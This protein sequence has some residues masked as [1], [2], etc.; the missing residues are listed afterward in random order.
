[1]DQPSAEAVLVAQ[2]LVGDAACLGVQPAE[3]PMNRRETASDIRR[4]YRAADAPTMSSA[5]DYGL[6]E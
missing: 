5:R 4:K 6:R 1:V 2:E 3:E